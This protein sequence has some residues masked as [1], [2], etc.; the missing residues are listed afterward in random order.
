[1]TEMRLQKFLSAAGVCSRRKGEKLIQAGKVLVNGKV[2][3]KLGS[4][5]DPE[6]DR[7]E[8][9]GRV[10]SVASKEVYIALHKPKGYITSCEQKNSKIVLDLIGSDERIYP[11]GRLDKDSTGL[12]LLTNNG[13][14]HQKLTHP[15]Y[16]HEKEYDVS[17]ASSISDRQLKQLS[18]GVIILGRK[19]RPAKI[20][21]KSEKRFRIILQEGRNRQIR[22]MVEKVGNQVVKLKRLRV[23]GISLGKLKVGAWRYLTDKEIKNLKKIV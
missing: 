4:K 16:D 19:T 15:S 18:D 17:V 12:L 8:Y 6:K 2:V 1:M 13:S 9:Q 7:V 11:I 10:L 22:R 5:I 21:R 23:S 20:I 3:N 14:L